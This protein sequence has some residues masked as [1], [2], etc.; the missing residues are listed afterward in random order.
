MKRSIDLDAARAE[1]TPIEVTFK[2]QTFTLPGELPLDVFDPL[3]SDDLDLVG[4]IRKAWS[5]PDLAD[6]VIETLLAPGNVPAKLLAAI[7][8][9]FRLLFADEDAANPDAEF[10][11]F[12]AC[13][14]SAQD[15]RRLISHLARLYGVSLGEVFASLITS[16]T[17]G[18]ATQSTTSP[19]STGSTPEPSGDAPASEPDSS[20]PGD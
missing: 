3:L 19:D 8:E 10:D 16:P 13:R 4:M 17:A 7:R 12:M 11:R 14:P 5:N 15:F 2:G 18:G 6:G 20:E 9:G 1:S